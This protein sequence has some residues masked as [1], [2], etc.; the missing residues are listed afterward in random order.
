MVKEYI[1]VAPARNEEQFLPQVIDSVA[2]SSVQP[3]LWLIVDDN[4]TDETPKIIKRSAIE[5]DY[6]M[7]LSLSENSERSS[8]HYSYVC[9]RGFDTAI[10]LA[11]EKGMDWDYMILL[12]ADTIVDPQYFEDIMFEMEKNPKIGIASGDVYLL[13][14]GKVRAIKAPRDMPSGTARVWRKKCFYETGGYLLTYAPDSVSRVKAKLRGWKTVRFKEYNAYQ[15]RQT[16]SAEGLWN[17][18][19]MDGNKAYYLNKHPLLIF[20]N[21]IYFTTKKPYYTGIAFLYGYL[22]SVF[23]RKEK[24]DDEEIRDYY[25][26]TRLKEY[27]NVFFEK[28]KGR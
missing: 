13:K 19:K 24:I 1:L 14:N 12:N 11:V 20:L 3:L 16:S 23:K 15:L 9:K 10:K 27:K 28:L 25:W 2:N 7:L 22:I 6:I 18:F 8:F 26:N 21:A 4:S 5:N 17:G